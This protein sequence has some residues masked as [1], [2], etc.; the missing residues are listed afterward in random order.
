MARAAFIP[1]GSY[2]STPFARWQG[3][4]SHLHSLRF[5]AW[6][7]QR[8]LAAR[9]LQ[10]ATIDF[11][12]LGTT[13]PQQGAFY[14]LPW[15]TGMMGREQVAGPT[16][17]QACATSARMIA[18]AA[19][20]VA[21]GSAECALLLAADRVSNGPALYHPDPTGPGGNGVH[22]NWVL[23]NFQK[24]PYAGLSM[25]QTAENVARRHGITPQEQ[26]EVTL[27]RYGQYAEALAN[28]RAFQRRYMRLPFEVPD[29][30]FRRVLRTLEGDEGVHHTSAQGLAALQPVLEGGTVTFG[31]QTHPADGNAGMF[32]CS[33][34]RARELSARPEIR[35]QVLAT[36]QARAEKGFMPAA[37][38]PAAR[39]ALARAGLQARSLTHVKTHN[40]FVLTDIVVARELDFPVEKINGYGCSLVW[41]HPQGPTGMRAV[42]EL[43]EQMALE[44]GGVGLFTGCAAGDSA[45]AVLLRVDDA[46]SAA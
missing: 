18:M 15:V 35:I 24:D 41:G 13:V 17:S 27:R 1:Y 12:V 44:G 38:V 32:V 19:D 23:D 7:A 42:I 2:W 46:R 45:M 16:V 21:A 28:D 22:E 8:E 3:A 4:L 43:I 40:P 36:G 34:A 31:G 6:Q 39:D 10:H 33:Q 20:A 30:S 11:G 37:T 29:K 9:E 25:L 26:N 5:A 14:G